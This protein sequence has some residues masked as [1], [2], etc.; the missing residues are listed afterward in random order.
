MLEPDLPY[1]YEFESSNPDQNI[2]AVFYPVGVCDFAVQKLKIPKCDKCLFVGRIDD[3]YRSTFIIPYPRKLN[4][5]KSFIFI[6]DN[7]LRESNVSN[8]TDLLKNNDVT[9]LPITKNNSGQN[10]ILR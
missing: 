3:D 4:D 5:E 8:I 9:F 6:T 10:I 2:S 7:A 1:S